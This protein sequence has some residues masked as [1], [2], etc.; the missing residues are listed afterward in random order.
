MKFERPRVLP[1]LVVIGFF[2]LVAVVVLGTPE[3]ST[4]PEGIDFPTTADIGDAFFGEFLGV[5]EIT[6][7]LLVASL[8]AGVYLAL[9]EKTRREAVRNAVEAKPRVEGDDFVREQEEVDD[10]S[11]CV[12]TS[13]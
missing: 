13:F 8:V 12:T 10:G 9:P 1:A 4:A 5:F 7:V 6:A 2:T 3:I 11:N